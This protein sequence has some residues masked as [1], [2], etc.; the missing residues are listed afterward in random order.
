MQLAGMGTRSTEE[1]SPSPSRIAEIAELLTA[2]LM[3]LRAR[4]S[5]PILA[6]SKE[7]S[8]HISPAKSGHPDLAI[9][10]E[11]DDR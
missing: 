8:L 11:P 2:G 1:N 10:R 6:D 9:R 4:K 5:S 7:S 3:R